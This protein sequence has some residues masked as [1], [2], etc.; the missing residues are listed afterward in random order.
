MLAE[1]EFGRMNLVKHTVPIVVDTLGAAYPEIGRQLSNIEKVI[2]HEESTIIEL[3]QQTSKQVKD[4]LAS[5]VNY[6]LLDFIDAPGFLNAYQDIQKLKTSGHNN[7]GSIDFL[8]KLY[9]TY[10]LNDEL[11]E[12]LLIN[13]SIPFKQEDLQYCFKS[14]K[15]QKANQTSQLPKN[16]LAEKTILSQGSFKTYPAT[17]DTFKYSYT[18]DDTVQK[19]KIPSIKA[20]VLDVIDSRIIKDG[21]KLYSVVLDKTNFYGTSGGQLGDRGI[22]KSIGN[23]NEFI[24][25]DTQSEGKVIYHLGRFSHN[26]QFAIGDTVTTNIDDLNRTQ[27]ML[28]HT[29]TH[30]INSSIRKLFDESI[31]YQ[32]SSSVNADLLKFEFGILNKKLVPSDIQL[33]EDLI[34]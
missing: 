20:T 33:I 2:D 5:S 11:I 7:I 26:E 28:H 17:N 9:D 29:A 32:K 6:D 13:E 24:V 12:K 1:T 14:L 22:L 4:V 19:Y 3:R 23:K 15:T 25:Y 18:F 34:R 8:F 10:G 16:T 27:C 31:V 21:V 30:L